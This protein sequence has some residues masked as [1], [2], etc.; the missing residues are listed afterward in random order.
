MQ[1]LMS[2]CCECNCMPCAQL[3]MLTLG[4]TFFLSHKI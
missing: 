2:M 4:W 1:M 3:A